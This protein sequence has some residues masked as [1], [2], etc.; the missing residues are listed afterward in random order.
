MGTASS[1]DL[2]IIMLMPCFT[3]RPQRRLRAPLFRIYHSTECTLQEWSDHCQGHCKLP[4]PQCRMQCEGMAGAAPAIRRKC[5]VLM[6]HSLVL[7]G[8]T[9]VNVGHR[10]VI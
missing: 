2:Q 1:E 8:S 5:K 3:V 6:M 10:I 4:W 9:M 7:R